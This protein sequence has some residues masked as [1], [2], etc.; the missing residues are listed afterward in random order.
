MRRGCRWCGKVWITPGRDTMP[1][2]YFCPDCEDREETWRK[3]VTKGREYAAHTV[4]YY[5]LIKR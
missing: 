2:P 1:D 5:S 4:S 3:I